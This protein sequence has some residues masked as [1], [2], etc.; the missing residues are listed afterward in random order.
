MANFE[1]KR[2]DIY[3]IDKFGFPEGSVQRSGRPAVIVSN[4]MNNKYSKVVE[5]VYCTTKPKEDLPTHV[6]ILSTNVESTVL[7]EQVTTVSV[8]R[9]T[10]YHGYC[11]E[12]E[13]KKIDEAIMV[14]LGLEI[15]KQKEKPAPAPKKEKKASSVDDMQMMRLTVERDTYKGMYEALLSRILPT[16][17]PQTTEQ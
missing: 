8:D 3:Y 1:I 16:N 7:C 5:V 12:E 2:G 13:M 4:D 11:T 17:L 14:S 6:K 15:Q 10:D 9:L